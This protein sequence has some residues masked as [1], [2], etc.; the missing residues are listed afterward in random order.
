MK[1]KGSF[2]E[3]IDLQPLSLSH[4]VWNLLFSHLA[5][6]DLLSLRRVNRQLRMLIQEERPWK[7]FT[8]PLKEHVHMYT[9]NKWDEL[10]GWWFFTMLKNTKLIG[11]CV[12]ELFLDMQLM[13]GVGKVKCTTPYRNNVCIEL[14]SFVEGKTNYIDWDID[15]IHG[16]ITVSMRRIQYSFVPARYMSR[17][18][19][20][21]E[22][23]K[24][25]YVQWLI[26][27]LLN[28]N[29][30]IIAYLKDFNVLKMCPLDE[31]LIKKEGL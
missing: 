11:R 21:Q 5:P 20:R 18:W 25:E 15:N 23:D 13:R 9:H 31:I 2:S 27:L 17:N 7:R 12:I 1:R 8:E 30:D 28:C 10:A 29:G 19:R 16:L 26:D 6:Y 24:Q 22:R 4:D 3:Y 14:L